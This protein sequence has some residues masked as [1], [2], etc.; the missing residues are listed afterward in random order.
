MALCGL[1]ETQTS[2]MYTRTF[3]NMPPMARGIRP[4]A[5]TAYHADAAH[6]A[7]N[8]QYYAT[9]WQVAAYA[10]ADAASALCPCKTARRRCGKPCSSRPC[11]GG[12]SRTHRALPRALLAWPEPSGNAHLC[13]PPLAITVHGLPQK[14]TSQL[15]VEEYY[16]IVLLCHR[17]CPKTYVTGT[18]MI[19][20]F[21]LLTCRHGSL[22][23]PFY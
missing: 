22:L 12:W 9:I 20:V 17:I 3:F 5:H 13:S 21:L 4:Q 19:R 11:P 23:F 16:D 1:E 8:Y 6:D 10:P 14:H 2:N 7:A 15:L 18:P